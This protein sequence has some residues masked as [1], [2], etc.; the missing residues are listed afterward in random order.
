MMV[1]GFGWVHG[2]VRLEIEHKI[3]TDQV[4]HTVEGEVADSEGTSRHSRRECRSPRHTRWRRRYPRGP[5]QRHRREW[6]LG[7]PDRWPP[8]FGNGGGGLRRWGDPIQRDPRGL[9]RLSGSTPILARPL[10]SALRFTHPR[11][12][13]RHQPIHSRLAIGKER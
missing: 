4:H 7:A 1:C 2:L 3:L 13:L 5:A 10:G 11:P 9:P 12:A 8:G 6:R